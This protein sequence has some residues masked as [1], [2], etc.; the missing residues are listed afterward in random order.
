MKI[1]ISGGAKSGKSSLAQQLAVR[2]S[3]SGKRYYVATMIPTDDEDRKRIELHIK[4]R[5]G[6]GFETAECPWDFS[7]AVKALDSKAVFLFDSVTAYVQNAM[8]PAEKNYEPDFEAARKCAA[9]LIEAAD[10]VE[11]IIF[12]SDYIYSDAEL[13][14]E[15]TQKYRKILAETDKKLAAECDVV[16]EAVCGSYITHKGEMP[17]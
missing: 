17:K 15:L 8:F 1:F 6:L 4:D 2:L 14:G 12:V 9:D 3:R 16:I 7:G 13:Y 11:N 5:E 10:E